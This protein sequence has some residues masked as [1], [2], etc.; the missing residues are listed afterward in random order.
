MSCVTQPL[1]L[2]VAPMPQLAHS[3]GTEPVFIQ[4]RC[5]LSAQ[6]AKKDDVRFLAS[7]SLV[8]WSGKASES[9]DSEGGTLCAWLWWRGAVT[10][11][12]QPSHPTPRE[13]P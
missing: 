5:L 4:F 10:P 9:V 1:W 6:T 11:Q 13:M 3:Y 8:S 7:W 2:S 12:Q